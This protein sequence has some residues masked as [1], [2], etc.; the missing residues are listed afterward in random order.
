MASLIVFGSEAMEMPDLC[1]ARVASVLGDKSANSSARADGES[2]AY[3]LAVWSFP[4]TYDRVIY[5]SGIL[6][7]ASTRQTSPSDLAEFTSRNRR[8]FGALSTLSNLQTL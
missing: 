3:V 6:G 8:G 4:Q 1:C 7:S 2:P 5:G